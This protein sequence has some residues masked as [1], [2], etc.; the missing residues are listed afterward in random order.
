M[1]NCASAI[2]SFVQR[3]NRPSP[4]SA[5][6]PGM[7]ASRRTSSSATTGKLSTLSNSTFVPSTVS[8]VS[9]DDDYPD[10]QI[11][12]S[13]NLK[14]YTFAELKNATKSFR[15]ESV[16]GEGGFGKVYKGWV[17]EKTLNPSRSSAGMVVAVKKL[18]PES[19]Q[20]MEQWQS[21]VNFLGR[22]SHPNLVKLLG[23]CMDDNELLLVYEFMAKGSLENHLFRRGAVYEPLPWSL[24]LKILIG[25]ARGLA[26]LHSSERQI[27]YRDFK[28]SNILLDSHFNAKLSDFGLAKHGPDGEESHV[29]TR[30][31][32]TYGYAAPEYVSTG[33]LYVKSDVYG[34]GVVL[35]EMISGL[36][37]LDPSR[38]SEK[39][40]LVNWARPLLAD[41]RKLS[42]VMDS[43]LEGQYNSKGAL[44]AAQL[45]L[46]C[47]NGDPKSRPSMKEVVEALEQIE[48]MK[49]RVR[50]PRSSGS[51]RRGQGQSPRR[52]SAR[53][54]SRGR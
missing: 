21:E 25:A 36:R 8:G 29:T 48:S 43:G 42:Q 1:G 52:D 2:D 13:P 27:I 10:G 16:L 3:S 5:S 4:S 15:P 32:G 40:N 50:E 26:F 44:L 6:T 46:K 9:A 54:N 30:V 31:M 24:R 38:Q 18:N 51:S 17:D 33:H 34:F 39:V 45:T 12:D 49:S 35:L 23:Y 47:L 11:L 41:R 22:I 19:V 14:I 37:A 28:A 20:G 53:R 7:S